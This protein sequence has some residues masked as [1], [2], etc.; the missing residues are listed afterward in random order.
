MSILLRFNF[1]PHCKTNYLIR[2]ELSALL[3]PVE[4]FPGLPS[5]IPTQLSRRRV[6]LTT[7]SNGLTVV[8]ENLCPSSSISLTFPK[9]GSAFENNKEVGA[10]L[11]NKYLAFKSG[12]GLSTAL[13][14]RNLDDTGATTFATSGRKLSTI[15]FTTH[16]DKALNI[17]PLLA[18]NCTYEKWDLMDARRRA[19]VEFNEAMCSAK[20]V[21]SESIF[22]A[23][24]GAQSAMGKPYYS[25]GASN[26]SIRLFRNRSYVLSNA[27]L[28]AT[29]IYD[30]D[31]FV[32]AVEE[33]LSEATFGTSIDI[34]KPAFIG[35]ECRVHDPFAEYAYVALAFPYF[36]SMTL[37]NV[38]KRYISL[39]T[40][41]VSG[42]ATTGLVGGYGVIDPERAHKIIDHLC[43]VFTSTPSISLIERAKFLAKAESIFSLDRGSRFLA[44]FMACSVLEY[45]KF[46]LLD[47]CTEYD[48]ITPDDISS[49]LSHMAKNVPALA[50]VGN[51]NTVP[52][53][54]SFSD[55]FS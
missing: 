29:G 4:E 33:G 48:S 18:T 43:S 49:A 12:S 2:R 14:T 16:P 52:Y 54:K 6:L 38:I 7:L 22:A 41:S 11:V 53:Q 19:D 27:V 35:S 40:Q 15:G 32:R 8:S 37:R 46:S 5:T 24:F 42:F 21:M 3:T 20:T 36:G 44:D 30:H 28:S 47:T 17:I 34:P 26:E 31:V 23:S 25:T 51:I 13:I 45:G 9:S 50:A 1:T 39:S 55:R 10:A